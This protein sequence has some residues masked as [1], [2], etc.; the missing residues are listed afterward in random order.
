MKRK[1]VR[2]KTEIVCVFEE[3]AYEERERERECVC[4]CVCEECILFKSSAL[5]VFNF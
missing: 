4:V 1:N 3:C 2:V 5:T